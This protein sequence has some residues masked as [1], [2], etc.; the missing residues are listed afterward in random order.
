[1]TALWR[2]IVS[3]E[4]HDRFASRFESELRDT[5]IRPEPAVD[6]LEGEARPPKRVGIRPVPAVAAGNA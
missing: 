6:L 1:M 4:N 2:A 3:D 5:E